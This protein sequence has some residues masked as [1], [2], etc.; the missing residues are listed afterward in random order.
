[1]QYRYTPEYCTDFKKLKH[2]IVQRR[3]TA[4]QT[5]CD[6]VDA[7]RSTEYIKGEEWEKTVGK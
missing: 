2:N 4:T 5:Q 6:T 1:M 3:T 7:M